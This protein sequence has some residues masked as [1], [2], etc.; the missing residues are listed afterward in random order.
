MKFLK[1]KLYYLLVIFIVFIIF[2]IFGV[3]FLIFLGFGL[4]GLSCIFIYLY[5][6]DF[7]Y[8]KGFYDNLIYYGSY[9]VLGYFI[10]F[11]IEYLMD[12]FKKNFLKN[13]YF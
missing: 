3:I 8:N 13:L 4:Y 12:Y 11:L 1:N 7:S 5:L 10:L 2:V 6:G 9:I